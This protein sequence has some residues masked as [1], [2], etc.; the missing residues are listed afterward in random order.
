MVDSCDYVCRSAQQG[1]QLFSISWTWIK[2]GWGA[3]VFLA[4]KLIVFIFFLWVLRAVS[5]TVTKRENSS[6]FIHRVTASEAM[7]FG[8]KKSHSV[9]G[10][11][12]L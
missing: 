12:A 6:L 1:K 4:L 3:A 5:G 8:D 9:L 11:G 2:G 10:S 7:A